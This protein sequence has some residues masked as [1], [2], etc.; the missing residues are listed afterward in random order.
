MFVEA[1][2]A[3]IRDCVDLRVFH[4]E[5]IVIWCLHDRRINDSNGLWQLHLISE[6]V[7][8]IYRRQEQILR[9]KVQEV[10]D[11]K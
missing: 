2:L 8:Q 6:L 4:S 9:E 7:M 3:A 1:R 10:N 11:E 5:R